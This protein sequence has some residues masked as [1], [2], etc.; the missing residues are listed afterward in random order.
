MLKGTV[1]R[2]KISLSRITASGSPA[3]STAIE[4]SIDFLSAGERTRGIGE[5]LIALPLGVGSGIV[6]DSDPARE[7]DETEL[8]AARLLATADVGAT[9]TGGARTA[10]RETAAAPTLVRP[11]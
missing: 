4:G 3:A 10:D 7:W 11:A 5:G 6:A 9:P 2:R 1:V 8:K